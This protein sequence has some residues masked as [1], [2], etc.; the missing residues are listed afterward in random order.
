MIYQKH[1]NTI[2]HDLPMIYLCF[3]MTYV[4]PTKNGIFCN[5][6]ITPCRASKKFPRPRSL[7]RRFRNRPLPGLPPKKMAVEL[8]R[9]KKMDQPTSKMMV[10]MCLDMSRL[11]N[12]PF[13]G[14]FWMVLMMLD[15]GG[16][17]HLLIISGLGVLESLNRKSQPPAGLPAVRCMLW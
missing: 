5:R 13:F 1:K 10:L 4:L 6:G 12:T 14:G 3:T 2:Y 8:S 11:S 17:Y 15:Y 16:I 7:S 9:E